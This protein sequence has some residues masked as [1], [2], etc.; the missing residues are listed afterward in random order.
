[1][2]IT[3]RTLAA[4]VAALTVPV[5]IACSGCFTTDAEEGVSAEEAA[6]KE[7]LRNADPLGEARKEPKKPVDR[8]ELQAR[9]AEQKARRR[10]P[11]GQITSMELEPT[12]RTPA[13]EV[14]AARDLLSGG[15]PRSK[16][17]APSTPGSPRTPMTPTFFW[18][19]RAFREAS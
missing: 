5:L 9:R 12:E 11:P 8:T 6:R 13:A 18:Q 7:K 10:R 17:G 19:G 3:T 14:A 1:M 4:G 15:R 2:A 16:A